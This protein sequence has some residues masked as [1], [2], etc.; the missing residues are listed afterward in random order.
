MTAPRSRQPLGV[1]DPGQRAEARDRKNRPML[2]TSGAPTEVASSKAS[3]EIPPEGIKSRV[4]TIR[5]PSA[6][7]PIELDEKLGPVARL[8]RLMNAIEG[9]RTLE[10]L[11]LRFRRKSEEQLE[12]E[13]EMIS[14]V[15]GSARVQEPPAEEDR[16]LRDG[17]DVRPV[18]RNTFTRLHLPVI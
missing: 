1:A 15:Q 2:S 5:P 13:N 11:D 14:L 18:T 9:V 4:A 10:L 7:E 6:A 3:D 8:G 16:R 17:V 12:V